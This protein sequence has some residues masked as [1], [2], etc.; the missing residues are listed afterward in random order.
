MRILALIFLALVVLVFACDK[1]D[2]PAARRLTR[3]EARSYTGY[4]MH[5]NYEYDGQ[6]RIIKIRQQKDDEEP[7]ELVTI[8]YEGN[9]AVLL[10]HPTFDPSFDYTTKVRLTLNA[11]GLPQK[12]IEYTY[13]VSKMIRVQP[14]EAF[15]YDTLMFEYDASGFLA[16]TRQSRYDSLWI[17]PTHTRVG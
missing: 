8:T 6:G 17:D 7:V 5:T 15:I 1:S 13:R 14:P 12:R 4:I 2:D 3:T 10:S 11:D 16:K 9:D